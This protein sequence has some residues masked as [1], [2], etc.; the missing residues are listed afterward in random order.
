M[1]R[2]LVAVVA[3]AAVFIAGFVVGRGSVG[4]PEV[5]ASVDPDAA[6][7]Q[8]GS[9][10]DPIPLGIRADVGAWA[11]QVSAVDTDAEEGVLAA[12]QFNV[13]AGEGH[14]YVVVDVALTRRASGPGVLRGSLSP[15]LARPDGTEYALGTDCGVLAVPVDPAVLVAQDETVEGQW[16]WRVPRVVV[17]KLALR[18]AGTG[19]GAVWFDLR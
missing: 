1:P 7:V 14:T 8:P 17:P 9:Q 5:G 18:V 2:A 4:E 11:L 10:A 16:C 3:L 12:N 15:A 19:G 13:P 6:A